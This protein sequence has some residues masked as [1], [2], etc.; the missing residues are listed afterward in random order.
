MRLA[1]G[2]VVSLDLAGLGLND[3]D[4]IAIGPIAAGERSIDQL[5]VGVV[6]DVI[7]REI[8]GRNSGFVGDV[9]VS[10]EG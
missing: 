7:R 8:D 4:A 2:K 6:H 9:E 10:G 5:G 3:S 1:P